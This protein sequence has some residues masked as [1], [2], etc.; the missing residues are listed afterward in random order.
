MIDTAPPPAAPPPMSPALLIAAAAC[1][2]PPAGPPGELSGGP[3]VNAAPIDVERF[4]PGE[5]PMF[6][7]PNGQGV[8]YGTLPADLIRDENLRW[9]VEVPGRGWG[10][11][12]VANGPDG[13]ATIYLP[14]ATPDGTEMDVLAHDLATGERKWL[15]K[16][17]RV[18]EPDFTHPT[19]TYAS[20]TPVATDEA[21]F[22][23]FGK[24]GTAR[25]D[26]Q[27]GHLVWSRRDFECD[28]FRGPASSPLL[29]QVDGLSPRLI[30]PFDGVGE[31]DQYV[32]A[33]DAA[34]GETLWRYDRPG[35]D[36]FIPDK[37]K[38]YGTPVL[39][40]W[41]GEP[42]VVTTGA[43]ATVAL[44][45]AD[46]TPVWRA[47]HGG[48]NS[49][50][51]P[52]LFPEQLGGA[53]P[54]VLVTTGDAPTALAVLEPGVKKVGDDDHTF[55]PPAVG[56][57]STRSAPK[58]TTP[59]L[60]FGGQ[61]VTVDDDGV[62]ALIL[63]DSPVTG[64]GGGGWEVESR[65]RLGDSYWSSPVSAG[66]VFTFGKEGT[67][68]TLGTAIEGGSATAPIVLRVLHK[69]KLDEGVWATPALAGGGLVL[70]TERTLRFY[71]PGGKPE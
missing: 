51:A 15:R 6:R 24:Y 55:T 9:S 26:P 40:E 66:P 32:V 54:A 2:A 27:N 8:G 67:A 53:G 10:S 12:V 69:E 25:L 65:V 60:L 16:L 31:D 70:R 68:A 29:V 21:I 28:H 5:W 71:H 43:N 30:V 11:P 48:M 18:A 57:Q 13:R 19:N 33:L 36:A 41:D 42:V 22:A 17:F 14:T 63:S 3:A 58:R 20:C 44:D 52:Q 34:T 1:F 38:A 7:G 37:R 23:H 50:S 4:T 45:P 47:E 59:V 49:G 39:S 61:F 64:P 46:G 35:L 62:A 56:W